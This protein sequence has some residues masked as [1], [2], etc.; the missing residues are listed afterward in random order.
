MASFADLFDSCESNVKKLAAVATRMD[1]TEGSDSGSVKSLNSEATRLIREADLSLRKMEAEA[2]V[3]APSQRRELLEQI[4]TLK[5]SL[6]AARA[7]LQRANDSKARV[8]LLKPGD[9]SKAMDKESADK[10][11][12][13]S[14]KSSV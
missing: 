10:L 13:A 4:A 9:K 3:A 8:A 6:Q 2:K 5:T 7:S 1:S 12:A 11:E 14:E